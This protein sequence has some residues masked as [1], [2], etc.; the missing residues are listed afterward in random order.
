MMPCDQAHGNDDKFSMNE[1]RYVESGLIIYIS[2]G[3]EESR[4]SSKTLT[5]MQ[6]A[7][8]SSC[9]SKI[10]NQYRGC[11]RSSRI[12][13]QSRCSS[14]IS[15]T[16]VLRS[17]GSCQSLPLALNMGKMGEGTLFKMSKS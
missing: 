6:I 4:S 14:H 10:S 12:S 1:E 2:D 3:D 16:L 7:P 9:F 15:L 8:S 5:R 13:S 11:A 17:C